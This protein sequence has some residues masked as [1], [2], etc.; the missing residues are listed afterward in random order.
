MSDLISR[1]D[2][3][4]AMCRE[5]G[6]ME[7]YGDYSCGCA[8]K[9]A[10]ESL[11]S[12]EMH[13]KRTETH[14]VCSDLISRSDAIES[15]RKNVSKSDTENSLCF[16][17]GLGVAEKVVESLPSAE[18]VKGEWIDIDS[19]YR[20]AT[21]SHCLKVTMFEKWGEYTRPYNYCPNCGAYMRGEKHE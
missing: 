6:N 21:C 2:A 12:A 1:Q 16:N 17:L 5:C 15:I 19:Y 4:E 7:E 14:S 20:M 8:E 11:P 3:I 9:N 13:D 10:I 18:A